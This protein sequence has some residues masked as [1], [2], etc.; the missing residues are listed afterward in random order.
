[1]EKEKILRK[2]RPN[3]DNLL[4]ILHDFQSIND[5]NYISN[6]DI[7]LIARYLNMSYSEI[8]GVIGYYDMLS[9]KPR[10][11]YVIRICASPV[12]N[13][14]DGK[15]LA[16]KLCEEL[17]IS[18]GETTNDNLF[19]LEKTECLGHCENAPV[20]MINDDLHENLNLNNISS[21]IKKYK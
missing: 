16:D 3:K 11:K 19:T 20:M 14:L 8:Y 18:F 9:N 12:C 4:N 15:S 1:M 7:K 10:G 5:K 6:S 21:I 13:M 17:G 2:Y